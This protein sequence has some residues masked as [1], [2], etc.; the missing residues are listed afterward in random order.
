VRGLGGK[1]RTPALGETPR[2]VRGQRGNGRRDF[3]RRWCVWG[4]AFIG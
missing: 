1:F 3:C 2:T 4:M